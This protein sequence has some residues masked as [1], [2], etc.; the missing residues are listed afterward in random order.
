MK[1]Y[2]KGVLVLLLAALFMPTYADALTNITRIDLS[3]S[4]KKPLIDEMNSVVGDLYNN[5][6]FTIDSSK[7]YYT[8]DVINSVWYCPYRDGRR[9]PLEETYRTTELKFGYY[10]Y[11]QFVITAKDGYDFDENNLDKI[12]VYINGEKRNDLHLSYDTYDFED[13]HEKELWI[14]M[15]IEVLPDPAYVPAKQVISAKRESNN[16][17]YLTLPITGI[18]KGYRVFTST[19]KTNWTE[20]YADNASKYEVPNLKAGT[21]YYFKAKPCSSKY[22]A[23]ISDVVSS[24]LLKENTMVT[25]VTNKTLKF[26]TLKKK[27][28][29]TMPFNVTK[30]QGTV[31]YTKVSGNAKFT[32]N[33]TNGKITVK[34]GTKKGTY[35]IKVKVKATGN[36]NYAS[37]T[38]TLTAKIKVK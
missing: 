15:P 21:N 7:P 28:L 6:V 19:D 37:K 20:T 23:N 11:A 32:V 13:I 35:T 18:I 17:I 27:K 2:F 22:C 3:Y 29:V 26:K 4:T 10:T 25:K 8:Y 30:A 9:C 34:K 14:G 1:N 24:R 16:K 12:E 31:T 5:F 33:K 38:K 36:N